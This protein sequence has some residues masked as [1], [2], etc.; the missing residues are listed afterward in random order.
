MQLT[1]AKSLQSAE[2]KDIEDRFKKEMESLKKKLKWYAENQQMLDKDAVALKEKDEEIKEL[3]FKLSN[4]NDDS[5]KKIVAI[6]NNQKQRSVDAKKIQDLE[7]QVK[8]MENIMK[9]RHPN[10]LPVLMW[11]ASNGITADEHGSK[12]PSV[13]YLEG[14]IRKLETQL[15]DKDDASR[16]SFRALEQKYNLATMK[17]ESRINELERDISR[18]QR[19]LES[20]VHPHT[21]LLA[22]QREFDSV[23]ER[24]RKEVAE[25]E[26]RMSS[27]TR[28]LSAMKRKAESGGRNKS[29]NASDK[30]TEERT[31]ILDEDEKANLFETIEKLKNDKEYLIADLRHMTERL[32]KVSVVLPPYK[33]I[34]NLKGG[35]TFKRKKS[36]E[37]EVAVPLVPFLSETVGKE[38]VPGM[39]V[40]EHVSD[41]LSENNQLKMKVDSL[42]FEIEQQRVLLQKALAEKEAQERYYN[43]EFEKQINA[44]KNHHQLDMQRILATNAFEHSVSETAELERKL[45]TQDVI[46][47]HLKEQVSQS[48]EDGKRISSLEAAK[49]ALESEIERLKRDLQEARRTHTPQMRHFEMLQEKMRQMEKRQEQREQQL[50]QL[51]RH[52][53]T[54][55][56]E[57]MEE[58]VER[59]KR[60]VET[61]SREID[62]FRSELDSM[63]DVLRVLHRQ[64]VVIPYTEK[65]SKLCE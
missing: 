24:H 48:H 28:E 3:R 54:L 13:E 65:I 40:G 61:K 39:F 31:T 52:S 14:R 29:E 10:S 12:P 46:I 59:W 32:A 16:R 21:T 44:L 5:G 38:Y 9:K 4:L 6:K 64:G 43:E 26:E 41:L 60:M 49:T 36:E 45:T 63:L 25:M 23:K 2:A 58:E 11:A 34:P 51:L 55:A 22:L 1:E 57:E 56:A 35:K 42:T 33:R 30:N 37:T 50:Q 27:L 20:E 8:E 7:R 17:Y 53:R 18:Y 15:E 47:R 62:S 19:D